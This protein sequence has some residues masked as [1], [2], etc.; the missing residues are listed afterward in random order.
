MIHSFFLFIYFFNIYNF[1][2]KKIIINFVAL[3]I[4]NNMNKFNITFLKEYFILHDVTID[5]N[6][7]NEINVDGINKLYAIYAKKENS[8]FYIVNYKGSTQIPFL[9]CIYTKK[10][11]IYYKNIYIEKEKHSDV[12][13][14]SKEELDECIF[15]LIKDCEKYG[16]T[17]D[18]CNINTKK[19]Y[20]C[21]IAYCQF[22]KNYLH[23]NYIG[24]YKE[25]FE[26]NDV[27][28]YSSVKT[29]TFELRIHFTRDDYFLD[30]RFFDVYEMLI[31]IKNI[32]K[33]ISLSSLSINMKI[34]EKADKNEIN[35]E[36][37]NRINFDGEKLYNIDSFFNVKTKDLKETII[38]ELEKLLKELKRE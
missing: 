5:D 37:N 28:F 11:K 34:F 29:D 17:I 16:V 31:F 35:K 12:L 1:L 26:L 23:L 6:L 36:N 15:N 27:V 13:V 19:E 10:N 25:N 7:K 33:I 32:I 14:K 18:C 21:S 2:D 20:R 30:K 22:M 38:N 24:K 4:N 3:I 8:N 9:G